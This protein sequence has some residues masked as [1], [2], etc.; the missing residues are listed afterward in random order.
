VYI[1]WVMP[2]DSVLG[3]YTVESWRFGFESSDAYGYPIGAEGKQSVDFTS[4][5]APLS[6]FVPSFPSLGNDSSTSAKLDRYDGVAF[7]ESARASIGVGLTQNISLQT[8]FEWAQAYERHMFWYWAGSGLIEGIADGLGTF[9][10]KA[11]GK[12]SP[13]AAPIV[14]FLVRNGI[15]MGFK[16]LRMNQMNW[17]FDTAPPLN[18]YN[19][20]LGI[21][22]T[23]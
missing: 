18:F 4:T 12:S 11:V 8:S 5:R 19:V 6:W 13:T 1:D 3:S 9:F 2:A 23:F 20:N 17:P 10:V 21:K 16:A 7:G 15:A 22:V 14:H